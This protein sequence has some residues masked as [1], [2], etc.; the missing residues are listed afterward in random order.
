M[1]IHPIDTHD[2]R[3]FIHL[4][5]SEI[6]FTDILTIALVVIA[7]GYLVII[8]KKRINILCSNTERPPTQLL[9]QNTSL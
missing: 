1:R 9:N 2:T 3:R 5:T 7:L 6:T 4:H 8:N